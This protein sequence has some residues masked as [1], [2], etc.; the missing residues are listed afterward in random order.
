[1]MSTLEPTDP[2]E[3]ARRDLRWAIYS[4][5]ILAALGSA[6]G[7]IW[8]VKS[9]LGATP[10]LSANDRSRWA[11]VRSLVDHGT[12][13]IDQVIFLDS[14]QKKRN[15]EWY[16][17][18]MVRHRGWDGR[19]HYYSSKPPLLSVLLAGA[20][21]LVKTCTG[22]TLTGQPFYVVR[23]LL[24]LCNV[25]P[26][27][28]YF[29]L[30]AKLAERYGR[31]D[32]GRVFVVAVGTQATFLTAF[33]TTLNNHVPGAVSVLV[34]VYATLRIWCEGRRRIA[35]FALAGAAATFAFAN[36]LPALS[37]L[38][39]MAAAMFFASPRRMLRGF[40]PAAAIVG[41]AILLTNYLAH[42]TLKPPYAHRSDG[43]LVAVV[44]GTQGTNGTVAEL[45]Q[46]RVPV[47]LRQAI[48]DAGV[49]LSAAT[50]VSAQTDPDRWVLWDED[51]HDRLAVVREDGV[52]Q[53]KRWENWYEYE[54]S[55]WTSGR[56]TGVDLGEPSRARYALHVL[57]GHHGVFS[58]T[59]VWLLSVFG[60]WL[61]L[62]PR[63]GQAASRGI[64]SRLSGTRGVAA[65]IALLSLVC[66][67]FFLTRPL[68][69]RNYGGVANG[70]RWL[71]WLIPLWL[72]ALLPAVDAL[73]SRRLGRGFALVLFAVSV[74]SAS[75][76]PLNP[77]QHPWIYQYWQSLGWLP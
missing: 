34:A 7:R 19:E 63:Q 55:Y 60:V 70:F 35:D 48:V 16:S 73:A 58:L 27:G 37:L 43:A 66:L 77:W 52:L 24:V 8:S 74:I 4:L 26:L 15:R 62:Q 46:R 36:E 20:Y 76:A 54:N 28:L 56:K 29:V 75:F 57:V 42:G 44:D 65:A 72:V 11:T 33:A 12:F 68:E 59:P 51:G 14:Q 41:A 61:W 45:E 22:A 17:I 3:S 9:S 6:I 30:L 71:F 25:L 49:P 67:A 50:V 23:T 39:V 10:L 40:L 69:D 31:T 53:V 18:D 64:A 2:T 1:M 5:L 13:E 38:A 32:W 21:W 47:T